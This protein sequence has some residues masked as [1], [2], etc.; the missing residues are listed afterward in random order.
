MIKVIYDIYSFPG[1]Q[2]EARTVDRE[3]KET[4]PQSAAIV[5]N[6][7]SVQGGLGLGSRISVGE[8]N[9]DCLNNDPVDDDLVAD[10]DAKNL[11]CKIKQRINP[12]QCFLL[13]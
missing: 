13:P 2:M 12:L 8:L 3:N 7:L 10:D 5:V 4:D 1:L 6:V 9:E 11:E